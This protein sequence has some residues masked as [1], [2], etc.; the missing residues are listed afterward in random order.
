MRALFVPFA[1]SL[2]H[3]SRCLA[4]AEAWRANKHAAVFALGRERVDLVRSAG[5][6]TRILPEVSSAAFRTWGFRWLTPEYFL[7]NMKAEQE[8]LA[9]V[10]PDVVVH[11]FRFTTTA[12]ARLAALP[13]VSIVHGNALRLAL[14]PRETARLLVGEPGDLTGLASLRLRVMRRVFPLIFEFIMRKLARRFAPALKRHSLP[15]VKSLFEFLMGDHILAADL[16]GMLPAALPPHAH[17][18]GPLLWSGWSQ[19][20][21]WLDELDARPLVYV[22]MGSTVEARSVL[23]G[24]IDALRDAP[25]NVVLTTGDLSL[26][27]NLHM[28]SHVRV[29]STLP[30]ATVMRYSV[31]ALHH[32]GHETL[33]QALAAGVPSLMLPINP[34]QIL[35]ARQAHLMGLGRSLWRVG[36][37]PMVPRART[38]GEIRRSVD[39][40]IADRDCARNCRAVQQQ[41]AASCGAS[42]AADILAKIVQ[43][44]IHRR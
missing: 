32:G 16:P 23:A 31:V 39:D 24:I 27:A 40:L 12:S 22:T 35:V 3:V 41:I 29:F 7:E 11:D 38:P 13:S 6:E 43:T 42:G 1:P 36:D 30:G 34:D 25:Y 15:A 19:P 26:T 10:A 37:M 21:P 44:A 14:H 20:A 5:F 18:V 4:V 9:E 33:M 28:P 17:V 8:I 2:A